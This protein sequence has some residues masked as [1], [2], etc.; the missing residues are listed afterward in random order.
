MKNWFS[1]LDA[2]K[3]NPFARMYD[4]FAYHFRKEMQ[5]YLLPLNRMNYGM[6]Y[7]IKAS[8]LFASLN[9][10]DFGWVVCLY[11]ALEHKTIV[12]SSFLLF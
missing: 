4:H 7:P 12:Q 8:S 6:N 9:L 11:L 1:S 5:K 3:I 10:G 2:G